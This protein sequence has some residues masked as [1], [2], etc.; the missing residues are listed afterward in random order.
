M[1]HLNTNQPDFSMSRQKIQGCGPILLLVAAALWTLAFSFLNLFLTWSFEQTLFENSGAMGDLRWIIQTVY[2]LLMGVPMAL[3]VKFIRIPRLKLMFRLWLMG[4]VFSAM[5]IPLKILPVTAQQQTAVVQIGILAVVFFL[6]KIF[7]RRKSVENSL[8]QVSNRNSGLAILIASAI[9][10]RWVLYGALG[11]LEDTVLFLISGILFGLVVTEWTYPLF[12]QPVQNQDRE[13]LV[14]DFLLDGFA[15]AIFLVIL[16]TGLSVNGSQI[17]MIITLPVTGWLIAAISINGRHNRNK[18][19]FGAALIAGAAFCMPL[20]WFDMDEL[21]LLISSTPGETLQWATQSA[22]YSLLAVLLATIYIVLNFKG[23]M[24]MRLPTWL[25]STVIVFSIAFL[26]VLYFTSGRVGWFGEKSFVILKQQANLLNIDSSADIATKR[27]EVYT[28][29]V[30]TAEMTQQKLRSE[31]DARRVAY[32]SYYLVNAIEIPDDVFTRAW[33]RSQP[34]VDRILESPVLRPLPEKLPVNTGDMGNAPASPGWNLTMIGADRVWNELHVTGQGIVIG[35]SDSGVDGSHVQLADSYRG[36]QSG[37]DYNWLDPWN[38]SL[39]PVDT[40][41]HGTAT[42]GVVLGKSVG[43]APGAQWFACV[44]LARNLGNPAHYLD[45]MQFM[46]APY[47]ENGNPFTYGDPSQGAMVL[48]NSW[49]CPTVEGCDAN[50]F[51]PAVNALDSAGIFVTSAA[52][53]TGYYGCG[54]VSD[55]LAIYADV[56]TAG[57][58]NSAGALSVFSSLGPV[59]VDGSDRIKPDIAAPGEDVVSSF[60]GNTYQSASGTSFAGPHVAGVV[61]L[62][63]SA[64]PQLIGQT[65]LTRQLLEQTARKTTIQ[66]PAC[67]ETQSGPNNAVGYGILNAY[68]AVIAAMEYK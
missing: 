30:D 26:A 20:I 7:T 47:P 25:N 14:S 39:S 15:L 53:N 42:L 40:E 18:G 36:K 54:S 52:G 56:L 58:V 48:N 23:F 55:P 37:N 4:T 10:V 21:F 61:A 60:P 67:A 2:A 63:W 49:G 28:A 13:I 31:L 34:E 44:N 9:A 46:L 22:W 1:T 35:Q 33:L 66:L 29:L 8:A 50:V 32:T 45:C 41:G 62:M 59:V 43:V 3:L 65:A 5:C 16:A 68:D 12:L 24:R 57:S 38:K 19:R 17:V 6:H 11:S 64:N 51:L 27:A